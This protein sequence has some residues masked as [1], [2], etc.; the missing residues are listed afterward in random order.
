VVTVSTY[1]VRHIRHIDTDDNILYLQ[2]K[3]HSVEIPVAMTLQVQMHHSASDLHGAV[4]IKH[5]SRNIHKIK[6]SGRIKSN[7]FNFPVDNV[8]LHNFILHYQYMTNIINTIQ[9]WLQAENFKLA[10]YISYTNMTYWINPTSDGLLLSV[11]C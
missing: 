9:A 4:A 1:I 5:H 11:V 2:T 8:I 6:H 3:L 7:I 10:K